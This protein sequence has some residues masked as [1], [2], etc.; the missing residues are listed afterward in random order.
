MK[1]TTVYNT[2]LVKVAVHCSADRFVANQTLVHRINICGENR[3]LRQARNRYSQSNIYPKPLTCEANVRS[4]FL[5]K[6]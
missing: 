4:I 5:V 3:H 1:R 6:I 2:G